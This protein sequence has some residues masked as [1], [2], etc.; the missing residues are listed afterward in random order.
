MVLTLDCLPC[1]SD[2][3][4]LSWFGRA[5]KPVYRLN[6]HMLHEVYH[7]PSTP[8]LFLESNGV[9]F[10]CCVLSSFS[11]AHFILRLWSVASYRFTDWD[12]TCGLSYV[13]FGVFQ[14]VCTKYYAYLD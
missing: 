10:R 13:V 6:C 11:I 3:V 8:F 4:Y 1:R 9:M 7:S 14:P 12:V 5:I 2:V